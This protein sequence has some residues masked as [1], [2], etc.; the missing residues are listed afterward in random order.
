MRQNHIFAHHRVLV[1]AP[2]VSA[3]LRLSRTSVLLGD[4]GDVQLRPFVTSISECMDEQI[5]IG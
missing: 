5:C 3:Q 1:L 4:G 2:G